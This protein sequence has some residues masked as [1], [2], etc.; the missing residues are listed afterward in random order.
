MCDKLKFRHF[1]I[2]VA[3]FWLSTLFGLQQNFDMGHF[4]LFWGCIFLICYNPTN[5]EGDK[6]T[7][8]ILLSAVI[9][10][11]TYLL[12]L[13][14]GYV[15]MFS[16]LALVC[17]ML[18]FHNVLAKSIGLLLIWVAAFFNLTFVTN[19]H[20]SDVQY[21]FLS[22]YNYIEYIQEN[23]FKFWQENPLLSRPSYSSYHPILHFFMA[24]GA[25]SL[26]EFIGFSKDIASEAAQVLFVAYMLWY[27]LIC[28]RILD[29]LHLN[30]L[31]YLSCLAL[32]VCFP[33]YNA[34]A[35]YFNN[36]C[37]L[38]PLQAGIIYYSLVYYQNGGRKNLAM[39]ILFATL[40]ALT[41]LSGILVLPM[42]AVAFLLRLMKEKNKQTLYEVFISG[43]LILCG[44]SLWIFYQAFVL[45]IGFGYVPPQTH[46]SLEN[47]TLWERFNPISAFV[48]EKMFYNDFGSNLWETMTKTALF[49]QW[50]F[51]YRATKIMSLVYALI[52]GYKAILAVIIFAFIYLIF[53]AKN[54]NLFLLS[55]VL[56][57]SLLLGQIA[58]GL[59]HPFMCNQDFRYIAVLPLCFA[60]IIAQ[61]MSLIRFRLQTVIA[62]LLMLFSILSLF[63][64]NWVSY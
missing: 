3:V 10:I 62:T 36:D 32:I 42:T 56:L 37:L 26:G 43:M 47:Y 8:Q 1:F 63:I 51:S 5:L 57:F 46:L 18:N 39:I 13:K 29:L 25:I 52:F 9:L 11:I 4:N 38:L 58:F 21:D 50:D 22:C 2:A 53:K 14:G 20:I 15:W 33:I 19:T 30:K 49:G 64:W 35:G 12:P 45:H 60:M 23:H 61:F 28:A 55:G 34:I 44:I 7:L 17:G 40:A 24:A 27:G 48:Y 54:K 6:R 16:G 59:K 41:K 31:T